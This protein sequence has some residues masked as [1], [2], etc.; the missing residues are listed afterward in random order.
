MINQKILYIVIAILVVIIV[1]IGVMWYRKNK[2]LSDT[3]LKLK[4]IFN[5]TN[6]IIN[7]NDDMDR[8]DVLS[9]H[10]R[11]IINLKEQLNGVIAELQ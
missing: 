1:I 4:D 2:A 8:E 3:Q 10:N 9:V 6:Y 7:P 5:K 11:I